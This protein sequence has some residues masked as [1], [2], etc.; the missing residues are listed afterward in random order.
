MDIISEK[1][2]D[3]KIKKVP[4]NWQFACFPTLRVYLGKVNHT[5]HLCKGPFFLNVKSGV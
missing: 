4:M 2:L 3:G 1:L 5:A